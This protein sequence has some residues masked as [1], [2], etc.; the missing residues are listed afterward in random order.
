MCLVKASTCGQSPGFATFLIADTRERHVHPFLETDFPTA[1]VKFVVR[2]INTGD[3]LICRPG[4]PEPAIIAC[5]E[6]KTL[7]DFAASFRDGR[8]AN[9]EKMLSL[10]A[11]TGCQLYFFVEGRPFPKPNW[12]IGP[13]PYSSIQSSIT[14]MMVR[15]GIHTV[16]TANEQHTALRLLEFIK[17]LE[18]IENP[19]QYTCPSVR[20]WSGQHF[21]ENGEYEPDVPQQLTGNIPYSDERICMGMWSGLRGID[22]V[23][24]KVLINAFSFMSF[25][26]SPDTRLK[27]AQLRTPSGRS[28]S[29]KTRDILSKLYLGDRGM[30]VSILSK[31]PGIST[32]TVEQIL[33][34]ISMIGLCKLCVSEDISPLCDIR[35]VHPTRT[36]K[37]GEIRSRRILDCL[38]WCYKDVSSEDDPSRKGENVDTVPP[39]A[40]KLR[41]DSSDSFL[42]GLLSN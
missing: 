16:Q 39:S 26:L 30:S 40:A 17:A 3:Y 22:V 31:I 15:D 4:Q 27:I 42:D 13:I 28:I 20:T 32:K 24:S 1:G 18:R 41:N 12:K 34:S 19:F 37:L 23:T 10:R 29:K 33:D 9:R 11:E 5:I 36:V 8:Y 38:G 7:K 2:Q 6:R 21:I 35:I 25:V 14:N